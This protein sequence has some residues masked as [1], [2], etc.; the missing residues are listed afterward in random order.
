MQFANRPAVCWSDFRL[1]HTTKTCKMFYEGS[2]IKMACYMYAACV[3]GCRSFF[4][5]RD[6]QD[7][8]K[9]QHAQRYYTR[10][11]FLSWPSWVKYCVDG[12]KFPESY[13]IRQGKNT[14]SALSCPNLL[15]AQEQWCIS[16]VAVFGLLTRLS[17]TLQ[18]PGNQH[19]RQ[20]LTVLC[21]CAA[22]DLEGGRW[23]AEWE[24]REKHRARQAASASAVT[25]RVVRGM[26]QVEPLCKACKWL[27]NALSKHARGDCSDSTN[28]VHVG[29]LM[30]VL[31]S[32]PQPAADVLLASLCC[33][34]GWALELSPSVQAASEDPL[35]FP[36][37]RA[38]KRPRRLPAAFKA[39]VVHEGGAARGNQSN[40]H[41]CKHILKH[42]KRDGFRAKSATKWTTPEAGRQWRGVREAFGD[43]ATGVVSVTCDASRMGKRDVLWALVWA[44]RL[45]KCAW[46][47]PQVLGKQGEKEEPRRAGTRFRTSQK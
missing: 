26:V 31:A 12:L 8:L 13:F 32:A 2:E 43:V 6:I 38:T 9:L 39:A 5:C 4:W 23:Q 7:A 44:A 3:D 15:L 14:P 42:S 16:S 22:G 27:P 17:C 40:R 29:T 24:P 37:V 45:S 28:A 18:P 25:V 41:V 20:F 19:A 33:W 11:I 46:S 47:P 30:V 36:I 21:H 1:Q 34:T 35:D 10:W